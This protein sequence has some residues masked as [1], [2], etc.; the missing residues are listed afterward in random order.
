MRRRAGSTTCLGW[1]Y[2]CLLT[3]FLDF[4]GYVLRWDAGIHWALVTGTNLLKSI[5]LIGNALYASLVGGDQPGAATLVRFYGW[6]I[7]GLALAAGI[8]VVWHSF[9]VAGMA[10]SPYRPQKIAVTT[11]ASAVSSWSAGRSC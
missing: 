9:R 10:G 4:T 1:G 5:P 11:S 2:S 8:L 6:H 7:F 3:I